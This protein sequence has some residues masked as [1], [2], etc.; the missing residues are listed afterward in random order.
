MLRLCHRLITCSIAGRSHAPEKVIMIDLF[1]LRIIDV[2][3]VNIPYLLARYLRRFASGRKSGAMISRGS[4]VAHL[5]KHFRLLTEQ[6]LYGLV[7]IVRDLLVIDMAELVQLQ[8]CKELDVT[9]PWVAPGQETQ[10]DDAVGAL[11]VTKGAP[12][13]DEGAQDVLA[14]IQAS[15][16]PP[17]AGPARSLPQRVARLEEVH[18]L[19]GNIAEQRDVLD[20]MARDFSRFTTWMISSLSLLMD[21]VGVSY[22]SY[23]DF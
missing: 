4:F 19:R 5:A 20:S 15:Q 18:G 7:V 17:V 1:Y 10:P 8:I 13:V 22:T 9:W 23:S 21:R 12:N 11:E 14:P 2:G 3:S 16:P 6:R